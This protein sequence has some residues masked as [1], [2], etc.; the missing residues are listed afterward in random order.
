MNDNTATKSCL[1]VELET[2]TEDFDEILAK[3]GVVL[4]GNNFAVV[5]SFTTKKPAVPGK[6]P[7]P[8]LAL[9]DHIEALIKQTSPGVDE[10]AQ[11]VTLLHEGQK[12]YLIV[13]PAGSMMADIVGHQLAI[14][15]DVYTSYSLDFKFR[16]ASAMTIKSLIDSVR[17]VINQGQQVCRL[18]ERQ[19]K[20]R[21]IGRGN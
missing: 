2:N 1:T 14:A 11:F 6:L 8:V 15:F 16:F 3:A 21:K 12:M 7:E 13:T 17:S 10:K 9:K 5:Y 19:S 18:R 20:K 4:S